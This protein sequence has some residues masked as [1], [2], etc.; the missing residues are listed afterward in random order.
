MY[1]T[2]R[3][4]EVEKYIHRFKK[5]AR[6]ILA[7]SHDGKQLVLIGGDFVFTECGITDN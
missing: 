6:P 1:T 7:A 2:V 4:G 5:S 3:D